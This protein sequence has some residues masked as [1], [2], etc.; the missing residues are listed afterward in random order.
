MNGC[1]LQQNANGLTYLYDH[2]Y[3][4]VDDVDNGHYTCGLARDAMAI[5]LREKGEDIFLKPE[6][7]KALAD[8]KSNPSVLGFYVE[9]MCLSSISQKGLNAGLNLGNMKVIMFQGKYPIYSTTCNLV[10]YIPSVFNFKAIDGLILQLDIKAKSVHL[11]PIQIT[12]AKNHSK[13][14]KKFFE[15]WNTW[16]EDFVDYNIQTT[17]LWIMEEQRG[18]AIVKQEVREMRNGDKLLNPAFTRVQIAVEDV[19]VDIGKALKK[20]RTQ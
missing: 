8:W 15:N 7:F 2:R 20:A 18:W 11:I 3:F 16:I 4:Y 10:L 17:F 19:N 13:S 1:L 9:G 5:I 6:W 12:I 14:E